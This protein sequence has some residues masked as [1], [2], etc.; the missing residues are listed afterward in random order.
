MNNKCF[1]V[2]VYKSVELD[3]GESADFLGE[4]FETWSFRSNVD[5]IAAICLFKAVHNVR[6]NP[7]LISVI[8]FQR[9][10]YDIVHA[11][12]VKTGKMEIFNNE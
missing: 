12:Y 5:Q 2:R 3:N 8:E 1:D 7:E 4:T 6:F 9:K 11:Y 10:G